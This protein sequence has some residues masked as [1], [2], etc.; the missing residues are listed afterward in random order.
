M[1]PQGERG[2]LGLKSPLGRITHAAI[3]TETH[4]PYLHPDH[5]QWIHPGSKEGQ[6]AQRNSS[7]T[8]PYLEEKT[9]A[10]PREK[11]RSGSPLLIRAL[12]WI[13][14]RKI[15][16]LNGKKSAR[17]SSPTLPANP[18]TRCKIIPLR[19]IESSLITFDSLYT[20]VT[21]T[22]PVSH[23]NLNLKITLLS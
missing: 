18:H 23:Y 2:A 1:S 13:K 10:S 8:H 11:V 15:S 7:P 5:D 9:P 17:T 21:N 14:G 19:I 20:L 22:T 16:R 6:P 12:L 4:L 3:Q